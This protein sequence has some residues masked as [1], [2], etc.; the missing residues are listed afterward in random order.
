MLE[1]VH[2][3]RA[4]AVP[5]DVVHVSPQRRERRPELVGGVRQEAPLGV[6]GAL[7]AAEHRVQRSREASHLV[8]GGRLGQPE[9]WIA[10]PLDLGRRIGEATERPEGATHEHRHRRRC[11]RRPGEARDDHEEMQAREGRPQVVR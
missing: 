11:E 6:A 5:R 1:L 4:R 10:C 2:D 8:G 9:T 7:E 3:L